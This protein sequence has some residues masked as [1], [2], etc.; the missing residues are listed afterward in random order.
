[1]NQSDA[2][3]ILKLSGSVTKAEVKKAYKKA[4]SIY[5]PDKGGSKEMMQAVNDAYQ[6]LKDFEGDL[7]S[8]QI[9][10]G[11]LLN[12]A[13]N[14][15]LSLDGLEI[16]V[17]GAWVWVTGE[18]K[19]HKDALGKNGA[20]FKWAKKKKAWYFRPEDWASKSRGNWSMDKIRDTHGSHV[21]KQQ[22]KQRLSAA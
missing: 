4:C 3:N 11:D 17:C 15:V 5:H 19:E 2:A 22:Q 8:T 21:V 10:Y 7:E 18:T 9:E 13:L 1:M 20:G 6:T 16:E 12:E 14:A